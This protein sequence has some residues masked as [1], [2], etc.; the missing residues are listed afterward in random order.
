MLGMNVGKFMDYLQTD[1]RSLFFQFS[2]QEVI[3]LHCPRNQPRPPFL[4]AAAA[5]LH[6][7]Y[8]WSAQADDSMTHTVEDIARHRPEP[9]PKPG[10]CAA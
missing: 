1:K 9:V 4:R 2:L 10:R 7:D 6:D 5:F 3:S 8:L